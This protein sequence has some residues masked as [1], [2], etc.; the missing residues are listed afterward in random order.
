MQERQPAAGLAPCASKPAQAAG[1]PVDLPLT[2][3]L[4]EFT[5]GLPVLR[6]AAEWALAHGHAERRHGKG[7]GQYNPNVAKALGERLAPRIAKRLGRPACAFANA[8]LW[9]YERGGVSTSHTDRRDLDITMSVPLG[10]TGAAAESWPLYVRQPSGEVMAWPGTPGAALLFDGRWRPHWRCP[11]DADHALVLLLH[12]RAPAVLWRGMLAP[13]E[14]A[15]LTAGRLTSALG[16]C[17]DLARLAV[18]PSEPPTLALYHGDLCN[19]ALPLREGCDVRLLVPLDAELAVTL[20]GFEPI[21]LSPGDG[22]AFPAQEA[23]RLHWRARGGVGTV[24][25]GHGCLARP[26]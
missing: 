8:F 2:V 7:I 10:L 15:G 19:Q 22:L 25:M 1:R 21:P 13:A 24:L 12:W 5:L 18:P 6:A 20:E 4:A 3:P 9:R 16:R 17:A 23:C 14:C 26:L 11:L